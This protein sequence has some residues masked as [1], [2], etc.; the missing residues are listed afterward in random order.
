MLRCSTPRLSDSE[1]ETLRGQDGT[2]HVF[3]NGMFERVLMSHGYSYY[4]FDIGVAYREDRDHVIEIA[5][6]G[7]RL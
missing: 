4:V 6:T 3:R 5:D 1:H 7:S 2:V